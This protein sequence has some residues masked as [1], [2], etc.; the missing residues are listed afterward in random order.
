MFLPTGAPWLQVNAFDM[1]AYPNTLKQQAEQAL[2][3]SRFDFIAKYHAVTDLRRLARKTPRIL[4]RQTLTAIETLLRSEQFSRVR[5]SYFLFREA[6]GIISDMICRPD[7]NGMG[8]TALVAMEGLLRNT[9]GNAHRG[10]AEALGSL[11]LTIRGP[12]IPGGNS[13]NAPA[14]TWTNLV[15]AHGLRLTGDLRYIGR[16]LV[17]QTTQGNRLLVVKLARKNDHIAGLSQ[18]IRW[19]EA[20]RK[21]GYEVNRRFHIPSPLKFKG[22]PVFRLSRLPLGLPDSVSRHPQGLAIAFVTLKDYFVYPNHNRVNGATATEILGR[23][24]Y[25]MGWLAAKGVIHD[26]PIPLFHNRTQRLRRDDQGRYQWFRA[27]RL[28][29]WLDSCAFPNFGLSGLRDFEHLTAFSGDSRLL[30]RHIGSHLFSLLLVA[31]SYFRCQ[32]E[33]RRG[34]DAGGHP[35]DARDL[36]DHCLLT[37]MIRDIFENYYTGFCG[38][39]PSTDL[40]IDQD[41]LI[42]RMVDEMGV[43]RYMS[44]LLRRVDQEQMTADQFRSFL[45]LKG[46]EEGAIAAMQP[47]KRDILITSGPHLGDFNRQISLPELIECVAAMSAVCIAGRFMT[48]ND[49]TQ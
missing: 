13:A 17:A 41:R 48:Q 18:E 5:Q 6:A 35:V 3:D 19:M 44:E 9:R 33:K 32:D 47:G 28:D 10:V 2:V 12:R 42:S 23:N 39:A 49:G 29:Q 31:G 24:A 36:F 21:P 43:D 30:Y 45:R 20:L 25:L 40:P 27:G 14:V 15:Q 16:S 11:P 26:A 4:D 22:Q 34:L 37:R 46:Y 38:T 1:S 8:Q 7:G